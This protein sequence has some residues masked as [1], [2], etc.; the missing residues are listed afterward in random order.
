M[1][2]EEFLETERFVQEQLRKIRPLQAYSVVEE[3]L[4]SLGM[5]AFNLITD[6]TINSEYNE[7]FILALADIQHA[8]SWLFT[9]R[10]R[11]YTSQPNLN[12]IDIDTA[13][14]FLSE[15][16]RYGLIRQ[17]PYALHWATHEDFD[18][19]GKLVRIF[20]PMKNAVRFSNLSLENYF[21]ASYLFKQ[22]LTINLISSVESPL[23]SWIWPLWIQR[24]PTIVNELITLFLS[25]DDDD[26]YKIINVLGK[27]RDR[28]II[29]FVERIL[30][31]EEADISVR[32]TALSMLFE[33][34]LSEFLPQ[35]ISTFIDKRFNVV[36][37]D[38]ENFDAETITVFC[39]L[40][41][42]KTQNIRLRA[43]QA[44]ATATSPLA[45]D[46][47]LTALSDADKLVK[48][49][50]IAS[51]G[52]LRVKDAIPQLIA[53]L[54]DPTKSVDISII[55]EALKR[56]GDNQVLPIL[57]ALWRDWL[58]QDGGIED[59][60]SDI[61]SEAIANFGINIYVVK[62]I[63]ADYLAFSEFEQY[64]FQVG[65]YLTSHLLRL[66]HTAV[67]ANDVEVQ[68]EIIHALEELGDTQAVPTLLQFVSTPLID[69]GALIDA[70]G[71]LKATT[72]FVF[73]IS[74]LSSKNQLLKSKAIYALGK[75]GDPRVI[76]LFTDLL[77]TENDTNVLVSIMGAISYLN[78]EAV[79]PI[80]I[81]RLS[82]KNPEVRIAAILAIEKL[83][84]QRFR[85]ELD[86]IAAEDSVRTALGGTRVWVVATH[87]SM[88]I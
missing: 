29:P 15:A 25:Q 34:G 83:Q 70:L 66:L 26:K 50:V 76:P 41:T 43:A 82:D 24:D 13:N 32:C 23:L 65:F 5:L 74:F 73:F 37:P 68:Y 3:M 62:P 61:I 60:F 1:Q 79:V 8:I 31:N 27:T 28:R 81:E 80:L 87:S 7:R 42:S 47:L 17:A 19:N 9:L 55:V 6:K 64:N 45:E 54:H 59:T 63:L 56:I 84:L 78:D 38:I 2:I 10:P 12:N 4:H 77:E 22:P 48:S 57:F 86:R 16:E 40:L 46:T 36:A 67:T 71:S 30:V 39:N 49:S 53:L 58:D 51:L 75:I 88:R 14:I 11:I 21:C 33:F 72:A 52:K 18:L 69:Q 44:L 85:P 35:I 20:T